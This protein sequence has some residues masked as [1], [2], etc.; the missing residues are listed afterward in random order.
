MLDSDFDDLLRRYNINVYNDEY[1]ESKEIFPSQRASVIISNNRNLVLK[2]LKWGYKSYYGKKL[3]INA[4]SETV[5][6]KKLFRNSFLKRRCIIP[7]NGFFEWQAIDDN[8]VR[9]RIY[10]KNSEIFSMAGI[11]RTFLDDQK[12]EYD[13]F[14]I[15][16]TQPSDLLRDIHNRMPV[17]IEKEHEDI[18]LNQNSDLLDIMK[19]CKPN[20]SRFEI[21]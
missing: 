5:L 12:N 21:A 9:K 7:A 18:W 10:L 4:R 3:I 1:T 19:V 13:A 2:N 14:T 16:T 20:L 6:E 15:L 17:I 8:K 11:Y